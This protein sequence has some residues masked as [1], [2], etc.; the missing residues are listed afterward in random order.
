MILG[1][2]APSQGE[3]YFRLFGVPVRVHPMFWLIS[4]LLGPGFD[5]L[6][7]LLVWIALVFVSI[8]VHEMGHAA[9]MRAFGEWP[10]IVLYGFGGL[11]FNV[12]GTAMRARTPWRQIAIS[13]AGP[14][15][16]FCA[17]IV[18]FG[19][20]WALGR[21]IVLFHWL[22]IPLFVVPFESRWLTLFVGYFV[23]V[24]VMWGV[25]NLLPV[26]PLDG[27]QVSRSLFSLV[28]P[29]EGFAWSLLLGAI[30]GA[31]VCAFGLYTAR[32]ACG[33]DV[34]LSRL[35]RSSGFFTALMF[36]SLGYFN[37]QGYLS[38]RG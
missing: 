19:V 21:P 1:Q 23:Q 29:R 22:G 37:Y 3:L 2:P 35:F 16:G 13:L 15:A 6:K 14:G 26:Y 18:L 25:M 11:T 30:V 8:L 31:A 20:F 9:A 33:D 38:A 32:Q 24:S 10:A 17:V 12:P 5:N 4:A 28:R 34:T 36:G 7:S 27:G